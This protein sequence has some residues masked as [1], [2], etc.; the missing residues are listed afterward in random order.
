MEFYGRHIVTGHT[1]SS[2]HPNNKQRR[3]RGLLASCH[4]AR[5]LRTKPRVSLACLRNHLHKVRGEQHSSCTSHI[6]SD[7]TRKGTK[8]ASSPVGPKGTFPV[9]P[10]KQTSEQILGPLQLS[11]APTAARTDDAQP[12]PAKQAAASASPHRAELASLLW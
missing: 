5:E 7:A 1:T 8:G 11:A 2:Y 9:Q 3:H 4:H 6:C 10:G 12:H